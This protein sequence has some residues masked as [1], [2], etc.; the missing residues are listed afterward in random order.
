MNR[1]FLVGGSFSEGAPIPIPGDALSH[2]LG[3]AI[4]SGAK[5]PAHGDV[6]PAATGNNGGDGVLK[7]LLFGALAVGPTHPGDLPALVFTET[8]FASAAAR[9]TR[10]KIGILV[11]RDQVGRVRIAKDVATTAAVMPTIEIT[12]WFGTGCLIANRSF[13]IRLREFFGE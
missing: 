6:C 2:T 9:S 3:R 11:E 7:E 13:R 5:N 12:K 8:V 1:P 10:V 4:V